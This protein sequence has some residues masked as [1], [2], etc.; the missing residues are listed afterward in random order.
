MASIR[1][2]DPDTQVEVEEGS[3]LLQAARAL[4]VPVGST[5]GGTCSCSGCHVIVEEGEEA[6]SAMDDDEET[7]LSA[8][9]GLRDGSRLACQAAVVG[10]GS[11]TV[12][13]TPETKSAYEQRVARC[14]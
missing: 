3:S 8:A 14:R 4:G 13:V 11:V 1:F 6:L 5:C 9:Y 2:V 10:E 7:I 12:R